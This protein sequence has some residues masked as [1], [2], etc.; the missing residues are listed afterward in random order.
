M[1]VLCVMLNVAIR[2]LVEK[3]ETGTVCIFQVL[4]N[5][6]DYSINNRYLGTCP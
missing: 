6:E 2:D 5:T 4:C 3:R 1:C